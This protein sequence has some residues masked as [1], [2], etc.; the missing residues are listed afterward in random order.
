MRAASGA[1]DHVALIEG[2]FKATVIGD[3]E[4][5]GIC[6][7][8]VVDAIAGGLESGAILPSGR[9]ANGTKVFPVSGAVALY[10]SDIRE[11]QLAKAAIASGFS[12]LLDRL[13]VKALDLKRVHLAGAFGNYVR[14]E[15]A[16]RIGLVEAPTELI[17]ASGN[18]ALRGAK[19][20]LLAKEELALP[21]IEHVR[22]AAVPGFQDR[23][24]A[25][26]S[27]PPRKEQSTE[28]IVSR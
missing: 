8:G 6:G 24:A 10:Q 26:M 3:V 1:I 2:E 20:M 5:R 27:L 19:M 9:V 17:H 22:L 16:V 18:T 21:L 28:T 7:S 13:G 4:A 15:S 25:C 12:L 11:L 14:I 23:F